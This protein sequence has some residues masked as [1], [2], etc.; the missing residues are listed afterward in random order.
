MALHEE[1]G[2]DEMRKEKGVW[3][4]SAINGR[5]NV[6]YE[7]KKKGKC[8]KRHGQLLAGRDKSRLATRTRWYERGRVTALWRCVARPGGGIPARLQAPGCDTKG[9]T[10]TIGVR[11]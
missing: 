11:T 1:K 2:N 6:A 9:S 10:D 3:G 8:K 5:S 4:T 7:Y